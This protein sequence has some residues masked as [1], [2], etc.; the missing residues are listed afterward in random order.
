MTA[1]GFKSDR[2]FRVWDWSVSH[3]RLLI[4]SPRSGQDAKERNI[5]IAFHGVFYMELR[6][7]LDG[8]SIASPSTDADAYLRAKT[9]PG[10]LG[11]YFVIESS[12]SRCYVGAVQ[13]EISEND[14][15]IMQSSLWRPS[16]DV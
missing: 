15:P 1:T 2:V 3:C 14:L 10:A 7:S 8:L 13:L 5:D 16:A 12:G 6:E 9:S 4:R 11:R